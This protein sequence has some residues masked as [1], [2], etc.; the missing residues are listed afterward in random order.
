[1]GNL[2]T[3]TLEDGTRDAWLAWS[4]LLDN[5]IGNLMGEEGERGERLLWGKGPSFAV[6]LLLPSSIYLAALHYFSE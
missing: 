3:F 5:W 1:M 2:T 6:F 4:L